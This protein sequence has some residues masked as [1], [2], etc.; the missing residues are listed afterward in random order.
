MNRILDNLLFAYTD[1]KYRGRK[2]ER[3]SVNVLR[4]SLFFPINF[5]YHSEYIISVHFQF[6]H[7][8]FKFDI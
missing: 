6:W 1:T 3:P 2:A 4:C 5:Q 8:L 7:K